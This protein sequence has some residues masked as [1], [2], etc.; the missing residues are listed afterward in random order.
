MLGYWTDLSNS[1][2]PKQGSALSPLTCSTPRLL[3]VN[4]CWLQPSSYS[5]QKPSSHPWL[6][7]FL[8]SVPLI[9]HF[10]L[11]DL[12]QNTQRPR[13]SLITLRIFYYMSIVL[14]PLYP[15]TWMT[16]RVQFILSATTTEI[17]CKHSVKLCPSCAQNHTVGFIHLRD[18]VRVISKV[19]KALCECSL[20][21][22]CP[23]TPTL[24]HSFPPLTRLQLCWPYASLWR[25]GMLPF[26]CGPEMICEVNPLA[27]LLSP[28]S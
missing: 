22:P 13:P 25:A 1:T 12:L 4:L 6:F 27:S 11:L 21:S 17:P 16:S 9:H 15:L 5:G 28:F 10:I 7:F 18:K 23:E 24:F 20:S 8:H 2:Y 19:E 26:G 14:N 3:H